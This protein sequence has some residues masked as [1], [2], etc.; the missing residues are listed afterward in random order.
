LGK[1]NLHVNVFRFLGIELWIGAGQKPAAH[2]LI[3]SYSPGYWCCADIHTLD[4]RLFSLLLDQGKE[5]PSNA[6]APISRAD[7]Q[8]AKVEQ[9]F[10]AS[11]FLVNVETRHSDWHIFIIRANQQL[12]TASQFALPSSN[13]VLPLRWRKARMFEVPLLLNEFPIT[14]DAPRA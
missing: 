13:D 11:T 2:S 4:I 3:E 7:P 5:A 14:D 8:W 10:I 1:S 12:I 6:A 9:V